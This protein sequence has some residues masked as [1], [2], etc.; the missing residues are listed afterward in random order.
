MH[1]QWKY[2]SSL[3]TFYLI[4]LIQCAFC[5]FHNELMRVCVFKSK[6]QYVS[7]D[8][9]IRQIQTHLMKPLSLCFCVFSLSTWCHWHLPPSPLSFYIQSFIFTDIH[10]S[11]GSSLHP[12]CYI[13]LF[14][15]LLSLCPQIT[16]DL[17]HRCTDSHT[18]TSASA[19]MAAAIVALALEAK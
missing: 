14:E 8:M 19:P 13:H 18:G 9:R 2:Y 11:V 12:F 16:T 4:Y 6:L 1:N 10:F 17:R 7:E 3:I 15:N 5:F